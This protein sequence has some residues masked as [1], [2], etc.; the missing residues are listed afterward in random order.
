MKKLILVAG[1]FLFL[2]F[3]I[4][5]TKD[6]IIDVKLDLRGQNPDQNIV[7]N[8]FSYS[9]FL[10]NPNSENISDTLKVKIFDPAGDRLNLEEVH[11]ILIRSGEDHEI[12]PYLNQSINNDTKI[13][14]F[15]IEG[16]YRMDV[17]VEDPDIRFVKQYDIEG[18]NGGSAYFYYS[19]CFYYYF[20][21]MPKWQYDLW[22]SQEEANKNI[23]NI[24]SKTIEFN[25]DVKN[26]TLVLMILTSILI[27]LSFA[28]ILSNRDKLMSLARTIVGLYLAIWIIVTIFSSIATFI[29]LLAVIS[30]PSSFK[31]WGFF[32]F[33]FIISLMS[34]VTLFFAWKVLSKKLGL[35]LIKH[36]GSSWDKPRRKK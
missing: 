33:L 36:K 15:N 14:P 26:Y 31:L 24:E 5:A 6:L 35:K 11:N 19:P 8:I 13:F 29:I 21:A 12:I 20:S 1:I 7:G 22:Q 10:R 3:Q 18:A 32:T 25:K 30:D 34:W 2:I 27:I 23:I 9:I 28:N 17:C 4:S 16:D